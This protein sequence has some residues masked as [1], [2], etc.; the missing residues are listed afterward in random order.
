[1][2]GACGAPEPESNSSAST[3]DTAPALATDL[4]TAQASLQQQDY[5]SAIQVLEPL[6]EKDPENARAWLL[7]GIAH[8]RAGDLDKALPA[9]HKAASF[10]ATETGGLYNLAAAHARMGEADTAFEWLGKLKATGRSDLTPVAFDPDFQTIQDDPRLSALFPSAEQLADPFVEPVRVLHE[11]VGEAPGDAFGWI[12]RDIG[13]VDGDGVHDLTTSAPNHDSQAGKV[14]TYS[15]RSGALLWQ[16]KGEAGGQLGQGIEA[17]GDT[18]KDGNPDVIAGAPGLEKTFV[19]SG[20]DGAVLLELEGSQ[21]GETFGATV[22]DIG[23]FNAD[24]H[25]DVLVGAPA[26]DAKA[27]NA[28]RVGIYSGRDGSLLQ[29]LWGENAGDAF[30]STAAGALAEGR[31]LIVIGAPNAGE[32]QR[33]RAYVYAGT[34]DEPAFVIDAEETGARLG[35]MFASVVG[36]VDG[37]GALDIYASDW[38]DGGLGPSTGKI[39]VHSG[40]TGER[41]RV[42][43]GEAR[44]DGF[45]IGPADAGDVNGDGH[46]DLIV[47]AWQQ[48][49]GAPSGGKVYLYSGKDGGLLRTITSKVPGETFGFDA[50]G[51][52]DVD[53]DGPIDFLLTSAWSPVKGP[54]SGRMF[55]IAGQ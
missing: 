6:T 50:T 27:E 13:D 52:G 23:D 22:T 21:D 31:P 15:G 55:L 44:G 48:G 24:G 45:G 9:H 17:A 10:E 3:E 7:L 20:K 14:Y 28:G 37:D 38:A 19:F 41:L 39:Y 4:A 42:L 2:L 12:A 34:G 53:G 25:D 40:A 1:L 49:S 47:G 36:D 29:E 18:N 26:N 46:A 54:R 8:H 33:G 30:G 51:M 5:A 32:G 11:W 43:A 35:G 16:H